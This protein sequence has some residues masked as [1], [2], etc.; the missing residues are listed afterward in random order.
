M[1]RVLREAQR[2]GGPSQVSRRVSVVHSQTVFC[3][4]LLPPVLCSFVR[5][6][7]MDRWKDS[8]VEKMKVGGNSRAKKFFDSQSDIYPGMSFSEIYNSRA[9]A[10]YRD[11]VRFYGDAC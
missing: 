8:E 5:S 9:A 11:K 2:T 4:F 7:T 6:T 10:L 3:N 1:P